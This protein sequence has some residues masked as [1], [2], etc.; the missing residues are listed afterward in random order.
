MQVEA[1]EEANL[2]VLGSSAALEAQLLAFKPSAG[3]SARTKDQLELR[4]REIAKSLG[5]HPDDI[6]LV[7]RD[8]HNPKDMPPKRSSG[9]SRRSG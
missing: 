8:A 3:S 4:R 9:R 5:K 6:K 1:D 7:Q 2:S